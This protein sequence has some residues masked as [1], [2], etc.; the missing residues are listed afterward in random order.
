MEICSIVHRLSDGLLYFLYFLTVVR[1]QMGS[2]PNPPP[3]LPLQDFG[4]CL[5]FN[6]WTSWTLSTAVV[7]ISQDNVTATNVLNKL[8]KILFFFLGQ[9]VSR[10]KFFCNLVVFIFVNSYKIC[11]CIF[12]VVGESVQNCILQ[13][14]ILNFQ[15]KLP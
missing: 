3:H 14:W 9:G 15:H 5:N 13:Y 11:S 12:T 6:L 10:V 4:C 8:F 2:S 7:N 1:M